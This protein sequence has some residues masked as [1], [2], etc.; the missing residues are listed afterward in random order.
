MNRIYLHATID[1]DLA[2][3]RLDQAL[4][5]LFPQ[6]SRAQIQSWIEQGEITVDQKKYLKNKVRVFQ[7]QVI[8]FNIE[9][10]NKG[11]W[12]PE[13][14]PLDIVFE[15]DW[16]CVI[17]KPPGL[18]VHPG[19]G[20]PKK[21]LVNA[22]LHYHPDLQKIPRAG[23]IHRLDKDTSGLLL[24]AKTLSTYHFLIQQ[25]QA[26]AINRCYV[27]LV[28]GHPRASGTIDLPI[29][30]HP[31]QRTKMAVIDSGKPS[32]THYRI[33]EKFIHYSYI[34][35]TLETG[36][37][38]Q[39]RVHLAYMKHP[40]VGDPVYGKQRIFPELCEPLRKKIHDFNRQA[41]HAKKI[42]FRHPYTQEFCE[43]ESY[44][45]AD[46]EDLLQ[47]FREFS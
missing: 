42:A 16:L 5:K 36:R 32:K 4:A 13:K 47:T 37:T 9:P 40:V 8:E 39:I 21:T 23:L 46:F 1:K 31:T 6:F 25:M 41:L 20:N 38:H 27:A 30:R 17:N 44:L 7:G 28:I 18:V 12:L 45:P 35:I 14:L 22:L 29:G 19:A 15:D 33:L 2:G 34:E 24:V 26:R 10:V 3:L 43:F 11:E